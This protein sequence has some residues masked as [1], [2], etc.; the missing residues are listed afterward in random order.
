MFKVISDIPWLHM[1]DDNIQVFDCR[2]NS[3]VLHESK[4]Q[5]K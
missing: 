3:K 2:I 4:E 5:E 1:L